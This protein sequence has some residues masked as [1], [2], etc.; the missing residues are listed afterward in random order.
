MENLLTRS[1]VLK[2]VA[3]FDNLGRE[4][5]LAKY[6]FGKARDYFLAIGERRY[7]SKA[8]A[9]AAYGFIPKGK[10]RGP[11]ELI[12]GMNDAAAKLIGLGFEIVPPSENPDWTWDEHVLALELYMINPASPPS[13]TS[14]QIADVSAVL[15]AMADRAGWA[16]NDK[17][18]NPNGVYMKVMNFRRFD[19]V[20]QSQDKVGL[21]RGNA[22]EQAV[23]E[24]YSADLA[25]LQAA[26]A[27]I[28]AAVKGDV[29]AVPPQ[30]DE[31]TEEAEGSLL[32]RTHKAR[33]RSAK[34][35]REKKAQVLA[36][37]G[38]LACEVCSFDF[39]KTFGTHGD[40]FVEI[41][42]TNP[43]ALSEPGRKTKLSELAAVC[44]N[45]HRMLHRGGLVSIDNLK[46]KLLHAAASI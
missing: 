39:G 14:K 8:I 32:V 37:T 13:K 18:R 31:D 42:H 44:S 16:K 15:L 24:R 36:A 7:D 4:K 25:G 40:G 3:E 9:G 27:A 35:I 46:A 10:A 22:Q 19:P 30:Q 38:S 28:R 12:G 34:L 5:F 45:C 41:H 2:A 21:T 11:Y 20:F 43:I 23:W 6:G 17:F 26:A 33:E 1:A 29:S